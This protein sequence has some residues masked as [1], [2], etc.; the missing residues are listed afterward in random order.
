M[1]EKLENCPNCAG[2]LD[3][4]GRC[5]FCGSKVYDLCDL[6]FKTGYT[7]KRLKYLRIKTD[8]G[9]ITAPVIL[10]YCGI[11][12]SIN[13]SPAIDINF[14]VIGDMVLEEGM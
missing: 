4:S 5:N 7:A 3:D 12:A 2:Y 14:T 13:E 11:N 6:D 1:I 10:N 9:V 8:K